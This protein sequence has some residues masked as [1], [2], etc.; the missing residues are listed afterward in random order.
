MSRAIP[1]DLDCIVAVEQVTDFLEGVM[2]PAECSAF[3][4]HLAM[5]PGCYAYLSQMRAQIQVASKLGASRPPPEEVTRKLL[6]L[7]RAAKAR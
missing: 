5:C 4:Q 2:P 1:E 3:E 6:D 7:F